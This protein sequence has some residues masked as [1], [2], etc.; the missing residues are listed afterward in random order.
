MKWSTDHEKQLVEFLCS[1]CQICRP[2]VGN[3]NVEK[4]EFVADSTE[5][6]VHGIFVRLLNKR[7]AEDGYLT[8][9]EDSEQYLVKLL[10]WLTDSEG[11][12]RSSFRPRLEASTMTRTLRWHSN[13]CWIC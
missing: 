11:A 2:G 3:E 9:V 10:E 4:F 8:E 7:T 1:K 12:C 13:R 6:R 5:L